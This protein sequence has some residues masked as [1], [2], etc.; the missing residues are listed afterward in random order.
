MED[1][2]KDVATVNNSCIFSNV[3]GVFCD[4][5]MCLNCMQNKIKNITH[6]YVAAPRTIPH[7]TVTFVTFA[8]LKRA[9]C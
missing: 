3:V 4:I 2:K 9:N 7:T 6:C 8:E 5:F 1:M